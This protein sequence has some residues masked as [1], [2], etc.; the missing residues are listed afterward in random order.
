MDFGLPKPLQNPFKMPSKSM[1]HKTCIFSSIFCLFWLFSALCAF[2]WKC[3]KPS[4]NCGFV[5]LRAYQHC[6]FVGT[7][8]NEKISKKPSKN[9]PKMR[10]EPFKNRCQK[11]VVFNIDFFTFWLRFW[12]V[13][14]SFW[15]AKIHDFRIFWSIF[16]IKSI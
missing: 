14:G 1:S 15:E 7:Q 4:K 10:S 6:V 16:S 12:R 11:R 3:L 2:S 9:P 5:A 13:L 8:S